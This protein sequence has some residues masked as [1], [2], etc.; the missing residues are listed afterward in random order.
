MA[1]DLFKKREQVL[2]MVKAKGKML[3]KGFGITDEAK[4]KYVACDFVIDCNKKKGLN[5]TP[6]MTE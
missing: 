2:K 4:K 6:R 3:D 1:N 5:D